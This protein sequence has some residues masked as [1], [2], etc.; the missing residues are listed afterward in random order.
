MRPGLR[1]AWPLAALLAIVVSSHASAEAGAGAGARADAAETTEVRAS[2]PS[3]VAI[4]VYRDDLAL[5]TETRT[6]QVPSTGGP[7]KVVF[8]GVFDRIIPASSILTGL[9]ER[10][11]DGSERNF[12]FDGLTPRALLW[13][14][15]GSEVTVTRG[16]VGGPARHAA[17]T[18]E[19][20]R[21]AAA[22][23]GLVLT[24]ADRSEALGC[25]GLPEGIVFDALPAGLRAT[26]TLS[27]RVPSMPAASADSGGS[28]ARSERTITLSYLVT[29]MRWEADY[30]LALSDDPTKAQLSAWLS[31]ANDGSQGANDAQL[32]VIA[33]DL[34]RVLD[35][36][37]IQAVRRQVQRACW[38]MGNT[39]S[40]LRRAPA[41][42]DF[43][44]AAPPPPPPMPAM[45]MAMADEVI[46]TA[47]PVAQRET[48][49]DY[50]LYRLPFPT[51]V[52]PAQRKQ[53]MLLPPRHIGIE[54]LY[55]HHVPALPAPGRQDVQGATILVRSRNDDA[56][57][58]GEPLPAGNLRLYTPL[59]TPLADPLRSAPDA[60]A[61]AQLLLTQV[62]T[63]EDTPVDVAWRVELG[64][65]PA[66][67]V[68]TRL[69]EERVREHW[70]G[71]GRTWRRTVEH[72]LSNAT[73]A[74]QVL[75]VVQT[76]ADEVGGADQ[77]TTPE[78]DDA[79][80]PHQVVD[81]LPTWRITLPANGTH[82]LRYEVTFE[83]LLLE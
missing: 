31:V 15:I 79:S 21:I 70:F 56:H 42:V 40:N 68:R 47:S 54:R 76:A 32:G 48:L 59:D 5:V 83:G 2:A 8:E 22:G 10:V 36:A 3:S 16:A 7:V 82:V 20:A 73:N 55:S 44:S 80:D 72:Q 61:P 77:L 38:P 17:A 51:D 27:A 60:T 52:L 78:I 34:A 41:Y 26:P 1:R 30:T 6:L 33:G 25:S 13:R 18:R 69:V 53:V 46:V 65:S 11:G 39:T 50:Q 37:T 23:D 64:T 24:F 49:Q 4:T 29:G 63:V 66:V 67:N 14:S 28:G 45:R 57:G 35:E 58:L 62:T 74:P 75:E 81:G 9:G 71:P 43:A 19:R 12:D